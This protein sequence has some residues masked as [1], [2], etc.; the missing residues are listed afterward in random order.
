MP[1]KGVLKGQEKEGRRVGSRGLTSRSWDVSGLEAST[2]P[3]T[4]PHREKEPPGMLPAAVPQPCSH[5]QWP[6][7]GVGKPWPT[8][9]LPAACLELRMAISIFFFFFKVS[10]VGNLYP[11]RVA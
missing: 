7:S 9:D 4:R 1:E 2:C 11:Q 5:L 6:P 10:L 3:P 8:S